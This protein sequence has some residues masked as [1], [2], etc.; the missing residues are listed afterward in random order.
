MNVEVVRYTGG[1]RDGLQRERWTFYLDF[2]YGG[3]RL[4]FISF[5]IETRESMRARKWKRQ[6]IWSG[7]ASRDNTIDRPE[8]PADIIAEVKDK[9]CQAVNA[10][11]VEK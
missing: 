4:V 11:E 2:S 1:L 8:V 6:H 9:I 7:R 10:V 5:E 3:N